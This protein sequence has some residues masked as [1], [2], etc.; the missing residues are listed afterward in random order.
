MILKKLFNLIK[1]NK[2]FWPQSHWKIALD[3]KEHI[4]SRTEHRKSEQKTRNRENPEVLQQSPNNWFQ[5]KLRRHKS[6]VPLVF[7]SKFLQ[8][9]TLQPF[10]LVVFF[11][12]E[13]EGGG[14]CVF[15]SVFLFLSLTNL[16]LS[17]TVCLQCFSHTLTGPFSLL[18][19]Y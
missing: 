4:E 13:W 2:P 10:D 1:K 19:L 16:S 15:A 18:T 5:N 12:W 14:C 9:Q 11:H 3:D 17:L 6:T 8:Q 7:E